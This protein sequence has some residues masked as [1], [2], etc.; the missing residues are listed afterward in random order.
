MAGQAGVERAR[1]A[2]SR[3]GDVTM[4]HAL[5]ILAAIVIL[6]TVIGMSVQDYHHAINPMPKVWHP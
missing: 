3:A 6:G 1:V 2:L 4:R 5:H